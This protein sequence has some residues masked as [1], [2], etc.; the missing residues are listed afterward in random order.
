VVEEQGG[1]ISFVAC[2]V[3]KST[4]AFTFPQRIKEI[5]DGVVEVIDTHRPQLAA[6]EDIFFAKN[7]SS[8]LKLGQARGAILIAILG[9]HLGAHEFTAKQVKQAVAGYGQASKAQVQHM[10]RLLLNLSASPS[11]DAA[12]ALAVALCLTNHL[13]DGNL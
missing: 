6:V 8:A 4:P 11:E 9:R 5:H 12:D 13:R 1:V 2:G 10:V 7:A 3:I